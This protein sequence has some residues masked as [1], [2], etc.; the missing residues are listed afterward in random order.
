MRCWL[1]SAMEVP[2]FSFA[3]STLLGGVVAAIVLLLARLLTMGGL[4]C[5]PIAR[6]ACL[7]GP[8]LCSLEVVC[9]VAFGIVVGKLTATTI[10]QPVFLGIWGVPILLAVWWA[11]YMG[12]RGLSV[13]GRTGVLVACFAVAW[14]GFLLIRLNGY[15]GNLRPAVSW[16][17]ISFVR[18]MRLSE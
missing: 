4:L 10:N 5:Y 9:A 18:D 1:C 16:E 13:G 8:G 3:A 14:G 2:S 17:M 7:L 12:T 6:S 11:A 15:R